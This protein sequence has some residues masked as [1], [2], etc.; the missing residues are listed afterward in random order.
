MSDWK[1]RNHEICIPGMDTPKTHICKVCG[2]K[3]VPRRENRYT[4]K[5]EPAKGG[6]GAAIGGQQETT[7]YD[8]F[9]CSVCGCQ[10]VA[11]RRIEPETGGHE[12]AIK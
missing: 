7:Y 10:F 11:Q 1:K 2:S 4:A 8:C 12:V 9:D 5:S 3:I 6:L